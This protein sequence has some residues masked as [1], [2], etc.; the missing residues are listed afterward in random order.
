MF[1]TLFLRLNPPKNRLKSAQNRPK[2][3]LKGH[4]SVRFSLDFHSHFYPKTPILKPLK[5]LIRGQNTNKRVII[6]RI[7]TMF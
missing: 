1:R 7:L 5:G 4:Y 6:Y 3:T 2:T